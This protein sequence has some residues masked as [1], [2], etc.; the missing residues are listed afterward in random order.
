MHL[1]LPHLT[2]TGPALDDPE[3]LDRLPEELSAALRA[4]N[5]CIA[6]LGALH[7]RGAA[8]S[9]AWHSLRNAWEGPDALHTLFGEVRATDVPFAEDAF[10]DQFLLREGRVLRLIGELGEVSEAADSLEGFFDG[11]WSDAE[12]VLDYQPLL[13]F[14]KAGGELRPGQL[15]AAYPPFVLAG[16]GSTRDVRPMD[17]I[18][19]RH[20]LGELARQLHGLPDGAEVRLKMTD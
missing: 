17:A 2:Y 19:R 7:V 9:P 16:E 11:L 3:I 12:Q 13:R 4:R 1:D 6:W 8:R 5:G 10:G 20:F 14:R 18:E 15:L